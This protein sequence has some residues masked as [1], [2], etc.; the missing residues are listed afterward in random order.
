MDNAPSFNAGHSKNVW[1]C[2]I[3]VSYS[4][5]AEDSSL[6]RYDTVL[7]GEWSPMFQGIVI[8]ASSGSGRPKGMVEGKPRCRWENNIK[9][10]L[11]EV[12]WKGMDWIDVT[13]NMD[14]WLALVNAVMNPRVP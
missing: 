5:V 8:S 3:C 7:L 9:M 1:K 14:T 6:L 13:Q 2:E 4:D 10:D 12:G 11:Q